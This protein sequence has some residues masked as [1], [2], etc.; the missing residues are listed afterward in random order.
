MA[1]VKTNVQ[2]INI[3]VYKE[4]AKMYVVCNLPKVRRF[5]SGMHFRDSELWRL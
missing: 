3:N 1:V 2:A 5:F 4:Y